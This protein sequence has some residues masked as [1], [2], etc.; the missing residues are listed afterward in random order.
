MVL[1]IIWALAETSFHQLVT[2]AGNRYAYRSFHFEYSRRI[3]G[4]EIVN[5]N[6]FSIAF[7][8]VFREDHKPHPSYADSSE[9]HQVF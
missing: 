2:T 9:S 6:G 3:M 7:G 1:K 4:I 8:I 5:E